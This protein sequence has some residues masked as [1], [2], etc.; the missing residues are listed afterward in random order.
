M[1]SVARA[2]LATKNEVI[3][4][5]EEL[6]G[7]RRNVAVLGS[8]EYRK[9]VKRNSSRRSRSRNSSIASSINDPALASLEVKPKQKKLKKKSRRKNSSVVCAV[10]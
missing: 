3:A 10:Q 1:H 6:E 7:L 4:L 2:F 9:K 5:R 8:K